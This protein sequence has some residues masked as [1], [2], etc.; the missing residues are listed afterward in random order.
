MCLS[1]LFIFLLEQIICFSD[2]L[3]KKMLYLIQKTDQKAAYSHHVQ[4]K[5]SY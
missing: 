1:L 5:N 4:V 3:K 2:C